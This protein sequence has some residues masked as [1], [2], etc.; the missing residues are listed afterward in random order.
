MTG[1]S[2]RKEILRAMRLPAI[3]LIVYGVLFLVYDLVVDRRGLF[4]PSGSLNWWVATLGVLVLVAR[5]FAIFFIPAIV[6][7]RL[8]VRMIH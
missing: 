6:I 5:L 8:V 2:S 4:A 3:A 1:G 7:Y